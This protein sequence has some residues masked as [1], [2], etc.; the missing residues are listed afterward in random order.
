MAGYGS[1]AAS[2]AGMGAGDT[3]EDRHT[4]IIPQMLTRFL[5][6]GQ[7]DDDDNK[8]EEQVRH[9][10]A[11]G[12]YAPAKR[13][14]P[15]DRRALHETKTIEFKVNPESCR[16]IAYIF[17]WLMCLFAIIMTKFVAA[18]LLAAGPD[19]GST[20][21]PFEDGKGFNVAT[22]SHLNRAFGFNN[23]CVNWDY[24]P[25]RELTAMV[26]PLF[27]YSLLI[28]IVLDFTCS[29]VSYSKGF[30]SHRFWT[31]HRICFPF[32]I[33][34][35]A[36]FRMIFVV[37]AYANVAGHTAGFLGL[38]ICLVMVA[39]LNTVFMLET[40]VEYDFLGGIRGTRIAAYTYIIGDLTI[41]GIKVYLTTMVVIGAGYP[42]WAKSHLV[43][44]KNVGQVVDMVWMIF[45]AILPVIISYIQSKSE[46]PLKF[47]ID[48]VV[49]VWA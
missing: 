19:D 23:I 25:S 9:V 6:G 42:E 47:T 49:P 3:K 31:L 21:A 5:A 20:C 10:G 13:T 38:Q 33:I 28:Y 26:Y 37:L 43:S 12:G 40:K 7:G 17:F 18:P 11:G 16:F 48:L 41:S 8:D 34:L 22:D 36:W 14:L 46:K 24:T 15:D 39:I 29:A 35:C 30:V 2:E 44:G 27:E 4:V 32:M 45:N 1:L